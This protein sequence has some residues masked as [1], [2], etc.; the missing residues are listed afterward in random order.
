MILPKPSASPPT[1]KVSEPP[2]EAPRDGNRR[3][4]RPALIEKEPVSGRIGGRNEIR[5]R[6]REENLVIG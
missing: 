4:F 5:I 3:V 1:R 2:L 6:P